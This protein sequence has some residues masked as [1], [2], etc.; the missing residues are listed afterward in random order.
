MQI[1]IRLV[2]SLVVMVAAVAAG[3]TFHQVREERARLVAELDRRAAVLADSLEESVT[4]LVEGGAAAKLRR[5]VERFG[6]RERLRGIA[7]HDR[8][9]R[10]IAS[11]PGV[12]SLL[13]DPMPPAVAAVAEGRPQGLLLHR[14]G[15]RVHL[16]AVPL[17]EGGAAAGVLTVFHDASYIDVRLGE[18]GRENFVRFCVLSLSIAVITL[19]VVRWS[20]A[21][22]IAAIAVWM[23]DLRMGR[24][25]PFKAPALPKGDLFLGPLISE[26][27][28]MAKSLA[29]AR[30]KTEAEARSGAPP[31]SFWTAAR[32]RDEVGRVLGGRRLYVVSNREPY[33]HTKEGPAVRWIVPPGGLVTALDPVMRA[34]EGLWIAH[35]SGDADREATGPGDS[36]PVP[37]DRPAYT[38]KRVWL[39]REEEEGYYYGFAN[40]GLWP[41]C[42]IAYTRPLFRIE[43]WRWYRKVNEKFALALLTEIEGEEAPLVLVQDYHLALL[44]ALVKARRPDARVALFWHIPWPNPEAYGICPWRNEILDGMLGADLIGFHIQYHCNNFLETVDR[45]LEAKVDWELFSVTRAGRTTLVKPFP[46][47]VDPGEAAGAAPEGG[48]PSREELLHRLGVRAEFLGIGVDRIDYTKGIPERFRAI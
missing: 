33:L 24:V 18:I 46:I 39:S 27:S 48:W 9:G 14:E 22:P 32:L 25:R 37:P 31:P 47:S 42:H 11:T 15:T 34:C 26:V 20:I 17:G 8:Q 41:L 28:Q 7:V 4:P 36:L 23:K 43:D 30:A 10:L 38:L 5:L 13:S 29:A 3:Y 2:V 45:F 44:P 12:E 40:E 21:G 35:G 16:F 19:L 6:N 1:T